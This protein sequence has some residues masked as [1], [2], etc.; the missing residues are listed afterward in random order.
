M[1]III[2]D[3]N[4]NNITKGINLRAIIYYIYILIYIII[5]IIYI[6][7]SPTLVSCLGCVSGC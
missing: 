3:N 4:I 6:S 2:G 5:V 7:I 1:T